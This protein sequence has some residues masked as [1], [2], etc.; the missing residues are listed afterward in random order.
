LTDQN[1]QL[2]G[3][4]NNKEVWLQTQ[5]EESK[6]LIVQ[7]KSSE[8]NLTSK[9]NELTKQANDDL[10]DFKRETL[11]QGQSFQ[12]EIN[13]KIDNKLQELSEIETKVTM[14]ISKSMSEAAAQLKD[15][16]D[17]RLDQLELR[18]T[19]FLEH[20]RALAPCVRIVVASNFK[21]KIKF[22]IRNEKI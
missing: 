4:I 15:T 19:Q 13:T 2:D 11:F 22:E 7:I 8:A 6:K 17:R 5:Q 9:V 16:I 3:W 14:F 12:K 10:K 21:K 18:R 1:E 20:Q